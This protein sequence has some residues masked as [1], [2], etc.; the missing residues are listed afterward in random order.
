[1]EGAASSTPFVD[2]RQSTPWSILPSFDPATDDPREYVDNVKFLKGTC[3]A[4]D[5]AMLAPR[6][7][8]LMKGTAWAQIKGAAALLSDPE[9]GVDVLL[10]AVATWEEN[11]E[12]QTYDKFEDA[13][14]KLVQKGDETILNYVN[15][16]SVAFTDLGKVD[17]ADMKA[18]ILLRHSGHSALVAKDKKKI[19]TGGE[20]TA[21]KVEAA[22]RSLSTKV[23]GSQSEPKK[24]TYPVSFVEEDHE[25]MFHAG[26]KEAWDEETILQSLAEQGDEDAQTVSGFEDQLIDVCQESSELSLCFSAYSEAPARIRDELR[27][28]GFWPAGKGAKGKGRKGGGFKGGGKPL[29]I[30]LIRIVP[31][32]VKL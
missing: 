28:R 5:R 18:F 29:E 21:K 11:S 4:R 10:A 19:I 13:L 26:D 17:V 23:L 27:A 12:L 6:L 30:A 14:Y 31:T 8:M 20:L 16:L 3:P 1:M 9:K 32:T 7:A 24:K 2:D 22:M 15:R 25:E